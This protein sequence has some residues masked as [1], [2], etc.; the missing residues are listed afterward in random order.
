MNQTTSS[1]KK[2]KKKLDRVNDDLRKS[3][4]VATMSASKPVQK[5][6]RTGAKARAPPKT[7]HLA[8][9]AEALG[10]PFDAAGAICPVNFNPA[11]SLMN[12]TIRMTHSY[13][14]NAVSSG[15][16]SQITVF[17]GHGRPV[18][19]LQ[20]PSSGGV[21]QWIGSSMDAVAYHASEYTGLAIGGQPCHI[22][23]C[24]TAS[25]GGVQFTGTCVLYNTVA[26]GAVTNGVANGSALGSWDSP[27]P[28]AGPFVGHLRWQLVSCGFRIYNTTPQLNRGGNIVTVQLVNANGFA[29]PDGSPATNQSTLENNPSF[30]IHGDGGDGV[31]ISWIPR[32]QDLSYWHSLVSSGASAANLS[33]TD[34]SGAGMGI[35]LNNP[36]ANTQTYVI[37]SVFNFML[38]GQS[39]Q[40]VSSPSVVEPVLRA[41]IEQ[42]VVHLANTTSSAKVAPIVAQAASQSTVSNGQSMFERLQT[43]AY[44]MAMHGAHAVGE[45][46]VSG[47]QGGRHPWGVL[48]PRGHGI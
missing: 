25:S 19:Q 1:K 4:K 31:E 26:A 11:P 47:L 2:E 33:A 40:T 28:F 45:G 14:S 38:A 13:L 22:G 24:N 15:N 39:I 32:L 9:W 12:T 46:I 21:G 16:C 29:N 27:C 10:N 20:N 8:R 17:P 30:K 37:Q 36:T 35:F 7:S 34:F 18:P 41:P 42:T 48:V 3:R 5:I 44:E 43:K 23:P 6:V